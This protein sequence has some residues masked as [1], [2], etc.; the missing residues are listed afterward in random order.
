[1]EPSTRTS[2]GE[3]SPAG[4]VSPDCPSPPVVIVGSWYGWDAAREL[5]KF[6]TLN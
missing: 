6:Q 3:A 4:V 5:Y 1:L 2:G